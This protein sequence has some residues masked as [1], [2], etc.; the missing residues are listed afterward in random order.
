MRN[1]AVLLAASTLALLISS[2]GD[3]SS[4][5]AAPV[6]AAKT[7]DSKWTS[8]SGTEINFTGTTIPGLNSMTFLLKDGRACK[9]DV[10]FSGDKSSGI[11]TVNNC[12]YQTG[13]TGI[14][15]CYDQNGS[16]KYSLANGTLTLTADGETATFHKAGQ[17]L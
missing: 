10:E 13:G 6:A 14:K 2:C 3:K 7:I 17:S 5:P 15:N 12:R 8:D 9:C 16:G 11:M 1:I 4:P